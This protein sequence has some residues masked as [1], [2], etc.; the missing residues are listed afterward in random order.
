M[1]VDV[2]L[3][4]P[5]TPVLDRGGQLSPVWRRFLEGL[6]RRSGGFNDAPSGA[7][8]YDDALAS[9]AALG[10]VAGQMLYTT[11]PD[12]FATT[13]LT[14][15][16]RTLLDDADAAAWRSTLGLGALAALG[17]VNDSNW[18]GT[19]LAISNGGTGAS[20]AA[21]ARAALGLSI[22]S[23]IQAFSAVLATYAGIN[24]SANVQSM[25]GAADYAAIRT[26]LSLGALA[27]LNTVGTAQ[28][29]NAAVTPAKLSRPVHSGDVSAA[30]A[31]SNAPAGWT[32]GL[33]GGIYT[34]TH[35]LGT[36]NYAVVAMSLTSSRTAFR[37]GRA[38]NSFDV[39]TTDVTGAAQPADFNFILIQR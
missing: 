7:Q 38:S 32:C 25:L 16:S 26:L 11:A 14:A 31:I 37:G 33:A 13:A 3:P 6:W 19:D 18:S 9:I 2:Q 22:G 35:N 34:I 5:G 28:I 15:F 1:A 20:T 36:T 30:G 27:L 4:P 17:T 12:S 10:L 29:D 21:A 23:D 39:V 24:P 8:P